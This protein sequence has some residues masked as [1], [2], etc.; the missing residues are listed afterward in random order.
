MNHSYQIQKNAATAGGGGLWRR[1][2]GPRSKGG[3]DL[4]PESLDTAGD[5]PFIFQTCGF[6]IAVVQ[7]LALAMWQFK[8]RN[9]PLRLQI[10]NMSVR[11][12]YSSF[13]AGRKWPGDPNPLA[14]RCF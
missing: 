1:I 11:S 9:Q 13:F 8:D 2:N 7:D 3:G 10:G 12:I 14:S 5:E 4:G 6:F